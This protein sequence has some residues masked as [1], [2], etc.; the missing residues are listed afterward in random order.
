MCREIIPF[1]S[2]GSYQCFNEEEELVAWK[3]V[4]ENLDGVY[5]RTSWRI[6]KS[7]DGWTCPVKPG[8]RC[9]CHLCIKGWYPKTTGNGYHVFIDE[10]GAKA[11]LDRESPVFPGLKIVKVL[12]KGEAIPFKFEGHIGY[13]VSQW[14]PVEKSES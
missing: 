14:K 5:Y 11:Y 9:T 10:E 12:I 7:K 3:V 4:R 2:P 6:G 8:C 1:Y 13:A